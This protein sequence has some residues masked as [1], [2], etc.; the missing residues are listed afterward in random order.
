MLHAVPLSF[1]EA[2]TNLGEKRIGLMSVA[3]IIAVKEEVKE[4]R[5]FHIGRRLG[6][7]VL[8]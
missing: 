2:K 1:A 8:V 6:V 5:K 4:E 7:G 3:N